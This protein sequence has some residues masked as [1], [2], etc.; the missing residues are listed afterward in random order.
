[1]TWGS[2]T[3]HWMRKAKC[4]NTCIMWRHLGKKQKHNHVIQKNARVCM[5][6]K[7]VSISFIWKCSVFYTMTSLKWKY[8]FESPSATWQSLW[9]GP[10]PHMHVQRVSG[11]PG[12]IGGSREHRH[13]TDCIT[14]APDGT[15]AG[16]ARESKDL[17]PHLGIEKRFKIVKFWIWRSLGMSYPIYF[18]YIF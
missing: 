1:M 16:R 3:Q 12:S 10:G 14:N 11:P 4:R 9:H 6:L 13:R 17:P 7:N 2:S 5:Y 18:T 8:I 15:D